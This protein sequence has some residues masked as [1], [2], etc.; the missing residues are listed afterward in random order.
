MVYQINKMKTISKGRCTSK[1]QIEYDCIRSLCF[2]Q[3]DK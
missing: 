1:Q 3:I 2:R